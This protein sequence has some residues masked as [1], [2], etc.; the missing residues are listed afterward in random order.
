MLTLFIL[1]TPEFKPILHTARL[2]G[3]EIHHQDDYYEATS[4]EPEVVLERRHT[5]VRPSIWFAA[6]TG[7]LLG[8]I[9]QFDHDRLCLRASE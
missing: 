1:D 9:V 6:L 2:A 8:S 7:G 5:D 4:S 3:M